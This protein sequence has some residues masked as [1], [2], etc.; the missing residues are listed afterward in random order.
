MSTVTTMMQYVAA[1]FNNKK[2][3]TTL[4]QNQPILNSVHESTNFTDFEQLVLEG[5][6]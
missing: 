6:V 5:E 3:K 1:A 2:K 4:F